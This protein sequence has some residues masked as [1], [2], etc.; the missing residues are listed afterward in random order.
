MDRFRGSR[1]S[2][3]ALGVSCLTLGACDVV[4]GFKNAGDALFPPVK[5]YLDAPGYRLVS[6][7][8]RDLL[9]LTSS[10]LYVLARGTKPDDTAL[11]SI[12]YAVPTPC[13]V[14]EVGH[15]WASGNVDIGQAWIAY[16]HD[17]SSRGTFGSF[18]DTRLQHFFP[19]VARRGAAGST[20]TSRRVKGAT[21][22]A[23]G[24]SFARRGSCS[25]SIRDSAPPK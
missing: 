20:R 15:F 5:T 2:A 17:G 16:F 6:G 3:L 8:Y 14:P 22:G 9:L 1:L 13:S 10:E 12:R 19:H 11:Y 18:T 23:C 7:G 24:S 25:W 21:R 4:Q